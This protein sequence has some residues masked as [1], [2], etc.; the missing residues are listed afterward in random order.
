MLLCLL[1][2]ASLAEA[3]SDMPLLKLTPFEEDNHTHGYLLC[4]APYEWGHGA[5]SFDFYITQDGL[6]ISLSYFDQDGHTADEV[7]GWDVYLNDDTE[8]PIHCD[9]WFVFPNGKQTN[10]TNVQP[11]ANVDSIITVRLVPVLTEA[12]DDDIFTAL[13]AAVEM[14]ET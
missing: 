12:A 7:L 9:K 5:V 3:L 14:S 2:S 4:G 13:C 8:S 6:T 1:L 11:V 10:Y